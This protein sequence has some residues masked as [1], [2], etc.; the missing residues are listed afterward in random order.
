VYKAKLNFWAE[1]KGGRFS[2]PSSGFRPQI[3]I[4]DI[5]TSCTVRSYENIVMTFDFT[6]EH[7]V[8]LELMHSSQYS[9]ALKV[10]DIVSLFEGS[11]QIAEGTITDLI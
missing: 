9:N 3:K 6:V 2:P 10:G 8:T 1:D 11:K 5:Q 4:G 7:I